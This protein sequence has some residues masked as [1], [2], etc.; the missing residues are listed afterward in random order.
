M[1]KAKSPRFP[2][3]PGIDDG[4]DPLSTKQP[5]GLANAN[6]DDIDALRQ[7]L[8]SDT[9]PPVS[10]PNEFHDAVEVENLARYGEHDHEL[11]QEF[12]AR[13]RDTAE[14]LRSLRELD[15]GNNVKWGITRVGS[16]DT[17]DDGFLDTWPSSLMTLERLRDKFGPGTYYLAAR[18]NGKY[19]GHK[20][21]TIAGDAPR[22]GQP[23][24]GAVSNQPQFNIS[25]FIAQ[26]RELDR[27]RE[28]REEERERRK[29]EREE[30]Q[31]ERRLTL[32][33][34]IATPVATVLASVLGN[35]G[36][37]VATLAAAMKGPDPMQL[38]AGLKTLMPEPP[39]P[40]PQS[41]AIDKA[42]S[43]VE[44]LESFKGNPNGETGWMD[45]VKEIVKSAGPTIGP[46]INA[47]V[48]RAQM[49]AQQ[50]A[51]AGMSATAQPLQ[52]LA[53]PVP[54]SAPAQPEGA[55]MNLL[56]A[57]R[58]I[59][60]LKGK[61]EAFLPA[62]VKRR[63]PELY[64]ALLLEELPDGQD[65]ETLAQFVER[66]DWFEGLKSLDPRVTAHVEWFTQMRVHLLNYIRESA[67]GA[68]EEFRGPE[69]PPETAT[70]PTGQHAGKR[71]P[72][73]HVDGGA[74]AE[75]KPAAPPDGPPSLL[76]GGA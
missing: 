70:V 42:F 39:P 66:P 52:A 46:V 74:R 62:A 56:Q 68:A 7:A 27:Q 40:Q 8:S 12:E 49:A 53:P 14:V 51:Q 10:D 73:V 64:A 18:R 55:D 67:E 71:V 41:D 24:N 47:A 11:Q 72:V 6:P 9:P 48:Q 37:D 22:R 28:A 31:T 15:Q 3:N 21:I 16:M 58:L 65:P 61:I 32:I 60:W 34:A 69:Q 43:I 36:P 1:A 23:V 50:R 57:A 75:P 30:K 35:R 63:D 13:E 38:L 20:T 29:E 2:A 4:T 45:V 25:E 54:D 26:Q 5:L 33:A 44:R 59:P 19:A 76:K 17:A